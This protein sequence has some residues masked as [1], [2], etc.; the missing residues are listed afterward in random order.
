MSI[1]S[2]ILQSFLILAFSNAGVSKIVGAKRHV[3]MFHHLRL[4]NWFRVV[5]GSVQLVGVAGLII[6]YWYPGMAAWAGI[7]L[8]IT[9]LLGCL[10]HFKVKD[11]ISKVVPAFILT[12]IPITLIFINADVLQHPFS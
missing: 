4:T 8:G 7:W 6:G 10:A 12:V 9:M 11:P 1:L 5:T 2:I 3:E